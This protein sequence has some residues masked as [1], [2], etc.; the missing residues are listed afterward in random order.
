M[1]RRRLA[2]SRP[3]RPVRRWLDPPRP[4]R[5]PLRRLIAAGVVT[6]IGVGSFIAYH[7]PRKAPDV[8]TVE[9][10][11]GKVEATVTA[12][13]WVVRREQVYTA[14]AAGRVQRLVAEG[15]RVRVGEKVAELIPVGK[16]R[17]TEVTAKL[18]GLL[19]YQVDGLEA[20]LSPDQSDTWSPSWL[21]SLNA[22]VPHATVQGQVAAGDPL[23][24][25]VDNLSQGLL[26]AIPEAEAVALPEGTKVRLRLQGQDESTMTVR[27]AR[28]K[29]EG[30]QRLLYLTAPAFPNTLSGLRQVQVTLIRGSYSGK[31]LPRSAI[32]VRGGLQGIWAL[33][34][35]ELRF[36]PVKVVGG[37]ATHVALETDLVSGTQVMRV[38]PTYMD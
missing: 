28:K 18:S 16:G 13:A 35:I 4:R 1:V 31:V 21:H 38:A 23:F 34:G 30:E 8:E 17:K 7:W 24:K 20:R 9:L 11:D 36:Y 27:V 6:L 32:D 37:N 22:P 26:V 19:V 5:I 14:P 25:V 15:S 12:D 29:S 3:V 10:V 2:E 33:D